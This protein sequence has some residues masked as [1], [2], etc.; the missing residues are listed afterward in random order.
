MSVVEVKQTV[1]AITSDHAAVPEALLIASLPA[2]PEQCGIA[3]TLAL[4]VLGGWTEDADT[5]DTV[6]LSLSELFTNGLKH[7]SVVSG[8]RLRVSLIANVG[9]AGHWLALSVRD[10]GSGSMRPVVA[11]TTDEG[12]RGLA[13]IREY[14]AK[15]TDRVF[16][17][18][19]QVTAWLGD[20]SELRSQVCRCDC[21]AWGHHQDD[22]C[23]W[24]VEP[25]EN[26]SESDGGTPPLLE[27][28][29]GA[30]AKHREDV[31]QRLTGQQEP[32]SDV[33]PTV[34]QVQPC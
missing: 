1:P 10:C 20:T 26:L 22:V 15:I 29:C 34:G 2:V 25:A 18:G 5:V 16:D 7:H 32:I 17:T 28:V 4:K 19:Y 21:L 14:G 8:E 31:T 27:L 24:T 12:L 9:P 33:Q 11:K 13:V 23:T 30:C 3:R 6:L